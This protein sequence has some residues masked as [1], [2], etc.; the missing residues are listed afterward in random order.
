MPPFVLA[1]ALLL[2]ACQRDPAPP[3]LRKVTPRLTERLTRG[4][5]QLPEVERRF[6]EAAVYLDGKP[7]GVLKH[8]EL[9]PTLPR[10]SQRL[11]DGREVPRYRVLEY[12]VSLGVPLDRLRAA[13][14][15][16]GRGR[17][18]I[19]NGDE[20]RKHPETLLFSFT[21]GDS[22]K[23]RMHWPEE[24]IA[25]NTTIDMLSGLTLYV[26]KDPPAYDVKSHAFTLAGGPPIEGIPYA[27]RE[28][29]LKGTRVY[30]D[31]LL[32]GA[33]R[34]R[35]LGEAMRA[36][37]G[38][39]ESP[40]YTLA[41]W[42][43]SMTAGAAPQTIELI[44]GEDVVTRLDAAQWSEEQ[45]TLTFSLPRRSQGKMQVHLPP[46]DPAVKAAPPGSVPDPS[47]KISAVLLYVKSAPTGGPLRP[48]AEILA[49][50]GDGSKN[51][52][53]GARK[54]GN[55]D[56]SGAAQSVQSDEGE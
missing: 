17:A 2:A 31:G 6:K 56:G 22:G 48:L 25:V 47:P 24:G 49:D 51:D 8:S 39:D 35:T 4:L 10:R 43:S 37:G 13:H 32:A 42:L 50:D 29:A 21:R 26:D 52:Q 18:S 5:A 9:P 7:I 55:G 28:E 1:T 54:R 12:L 23:P 20:M 34:R 33:M 14:F 15:L 36:P 3:L 46:G 45:K 19:V 11:L 53:G 38:S 27:E 16:G 40:R 41:A 44:N 30:V